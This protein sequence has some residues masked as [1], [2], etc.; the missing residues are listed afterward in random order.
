[1]K[2]NQNR[3]PGGD[4]PGVWDQPS[5]TRAARAPT[6]GRLRLG[7]DVP[8]SCSCVGSGLLA[9]CDALAGGCVKVRFAGTVAGRWGRAG[10]AAPSHG[11]AAAAHP[12]S[13]V[14]ICCARSAHDA[15]SKDC[16]WLLVTC[17]LHRAA[18]AGARNC[19]VSHE[20]VDPAALRPGP[21]CTRSPVRDLEG[22]CD[23]LCRLGVHVRE[24][25]SVQ[26]CSGGPAALQSPC[27]FCSWPAAGQRAAAWDVH[28]SAM[29]SQVCP[30]WQPHYG[31]LPRDAPSFTLLWRRNR[32]VWARARPCVCVVT[33]VASYM[34]D[35]CRVI[36]SSVLVRSSRTQV[37]FCLSRLRSCPARGRVVRGSVRAAR[38][39]GDSAAA[40][41]VAFRS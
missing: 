41:A 39:G 38:R 21:A 12:G 2:W 15:Y 6:D 26:P 14:E 24:C 11:R 17:R 5:R 31:V 27:L 32:H 20:P 7:C 34:L 23:A 29:S 37:P 4:V 19:T 3:A 33:W 25:T 35:F 13:T 9:G 30:R 22:R 40:I 16:R 28:A 8:V 36:R 1:V 18:L 10:T